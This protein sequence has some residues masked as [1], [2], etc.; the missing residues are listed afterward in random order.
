[1]PLRDFRAEGRMPPVGF[2]DLSDDVVRAITALQ[3]QVKDLQFEANFYRFA[4][5][6]AF[7]L[8]VEKAW[9]RFFS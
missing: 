1:M 5:I 7:A 8:M 2:D 6:I 3:V 9:T 4:T